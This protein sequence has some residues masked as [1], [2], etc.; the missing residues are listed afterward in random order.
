[1]SDGLEKK[2]DAALHDVYK[3]AKYEAHYNATIFLK[4]LYERGGLGTARYL[5][6]AD[7]PSDGY[8]ALYERKRLDLTVEAVVIENEM[9]HALF[10]PEELEKARRRLADYGYRPRKSAS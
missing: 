8:T 9:W 7:K 6:N 2:F 10:T 4:M 5:I 3:K 1:M